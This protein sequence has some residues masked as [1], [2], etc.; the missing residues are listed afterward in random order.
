MSS[1]LK[2]DIYQISQR[3]GLILK[4]NALIVGTAE[5]C[6]GGWVAQALTMVPGSS[7]WFD[8]GFV[9]YSNQSKV[10]QLGVDPKLIDQYG[11]VSDVVV[12]KM[13]FGVLNRTGANCAIATSGVAGPEG[14]TEDK[15]VG[16]VWIG[17]GSKLKGLMTRRFL[18]EGDRNSVRQKSVIESLSL[19][20]QFLAQD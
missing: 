1:Y 2:S 13:L 16:T 5:S 20:E 18:F 17:V 3:L 19:M 15:P 10:Q 8:V 14:G 7:S 4:E 12:E 11:A 9:T 6:T